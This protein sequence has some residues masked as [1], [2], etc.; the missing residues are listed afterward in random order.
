MG[1]LLLVV[2]I[3][4]AAG[5]TPQPAKFGEPSTQIGL[6]QCIADRA[7]RN[8]F[9]AAGV[10]KCQ[11]TCASPL[12]SFIPLASEALQRCAPAE[13]YVVL[14]NADGHP[15]SGAISVN[16]A[17]SSALLDEAYAAAASLNGSTGSV[18]LGATEVNRMFHNAIA[19]R[20][21]L[22][23]HFR[24]FFPLGSD[25]MVPESAVEFRAIVEYIKHAPGSQVEVVGHTD[26]VARESE[27]QN[28]SLSRSAAIREAL[29]RNGIN[30][31]TISTAGRGD[32]DLLVQ[33][34]N[35]V[36]EPRNRRVEV[37]VR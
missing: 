4:T 27:N 15:G 13:V 26:T 20:P 3:P 16:Q 1:L 9:C 37:T 17:G 14:P 34:G 8:L 2:A 28:L 19:A 22:P 32:R 10:A 29:V 5:Q 24:L 18:A 35:N 36:E 12:Y 6:C 31:R 23:R 33:T 25:R 7:S 21:T 11:K 30:P